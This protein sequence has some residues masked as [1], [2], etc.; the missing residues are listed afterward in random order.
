MLFKQKSILLGGWSQAVKSPVSILQKTLLLN[1]Y[2]AIWILSLS[3]SL[4][5]IF[6]KRKRCCAQKSKPHSLFNVNNSRVMAQFQSSEKLFIHITFCK[7][8]TST[9]LCYWPMFASIHL[10]FKKVINLTQTKSRLERKVEVSLSK[11][12]NLLENNPH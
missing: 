1:M 3:F 6:I 5:T 12:N 2:F 8:I 9:E 4:G 10:H 7:F 11:Q